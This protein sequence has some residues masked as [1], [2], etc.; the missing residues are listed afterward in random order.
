MM[1][2]RRPWRALM[3]QVFDLI[4]RAC[5][6]AVAEGEEEVELDLP[7]AWARGGPWLGDD[8]TPL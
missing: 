7:Q 3:A 6:A 5:P 1:A 2:V 8:R 4:E